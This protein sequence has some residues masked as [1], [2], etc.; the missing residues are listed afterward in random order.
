[1]ENLYLKI[2]K[3]KSIKAFKISVKKYWVKNFKRNYYRLNRIRNIF[4]KG[5][6]LPLS[7]SS[8]KF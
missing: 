1:M 4:K 8:G 5:Y 2:K 7:S 3:I 6:G